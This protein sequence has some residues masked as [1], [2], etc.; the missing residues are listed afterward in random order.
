MQEKVEVGLTIGKIQTKPEQAKDKGPGRQTPSWVPPNSQET[1]PLV[2]RG[3][4]PAG[5]KEA[6]FNLDLSNDSI[7]RPSF[8]K[9]GKKAARRRESKFWI[10]A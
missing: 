4:V 8:S 5:G 7:L 6:G 2:L 3:W 1:P 10:P 9:D